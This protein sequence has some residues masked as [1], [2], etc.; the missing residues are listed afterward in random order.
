MHCRQRAGRE[1]R[2]RGSGASALRAGVDREDVLLEQLSGC[3]SKEMAATR[4]EGGRVWK[5]AWAN[6]AALTEYS[7]MILTKDCS[8]Q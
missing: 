3:D 7:E 4:P 5:P 6:N 1:M 2:L 8:L